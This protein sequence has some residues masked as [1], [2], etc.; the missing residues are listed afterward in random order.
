MQLRGGA[1]GFAVS[2]DI[3]PAPGIALAG[4]AGSPRH[5][6]GEA[7]ALEANV[8]VLREHKGP[9]LLVTVDTLYGGALGNRIAG[10]LRCSPEQVVMA[11]S[12]THFAPGVD[13]ELESLG[14]AEEKFIAWAAAR[15]VDAVLHADESTLASIGY[16]ECAT[17]GLFVNR[18]LPLLGRSLAR[19][20]GGPIRVAPNPA[21]EADETIRTVMI[22]SDEQI[23]A[24]I[25]GASC[26]P[27][28][29]PNA[30]LLSSNFPG[31]VRERI[32]ADFGRADLPVLFLQGF[33]GDVRP[34]SYTTRPRW[35]WRG[36]A[37]YVANHGRVFSSQS[38]REFTVWCD[39]L[40]MA[41]GRGIAEAERSKK[42]WDEVRCRRV[43]DHP[44]GWER[45]VTMTEVMLGSDVHI[46]AVN[47][48]VMSS[49]MRSV[50]FMG[51]HV[52]P[53]GCT[54]EVIGYWP[55]NRM[56]DEGGY[57]GCDSREHF[58]DLDWGA[59]S[60]D[61]LWARLLRRL[62]TTAW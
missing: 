7:E 31:V 44:Q 43:E 28:C 36:I 10:G 8:L 51:K 22:R 49:R 39:Q 1:S 5:S 20:L 25:W 38:R 57:E 50:A 55:T 37:V 35:S 15:I 53:V 4:Y 47:A 26:H 23:E 13:P 32:R 6:T 61:H 59:E 42:R 52:M 2:V 34:A 3:T 30:E 16:G 54:G 40:A 58:P 17:R 62:T 46:V 60:P 14:G 24:V 18:R 29:A 12:H 56:L 19:R 21:G 33:S 48:E 27:V 11:G 41:A 9:L 45:P